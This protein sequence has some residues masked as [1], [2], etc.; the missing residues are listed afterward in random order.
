MDALLWSGYIVSGTSRTRSRAATHSTA[1][2]V[3]M[4]AMIMKM[5]IIIEN[6]LLINVIG[7][8]F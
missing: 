8:T 5:R 3:K 7:R 4:M 2:F 1:T 6:I